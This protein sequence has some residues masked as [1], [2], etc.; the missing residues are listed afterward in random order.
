MKRVYQFSILLSV[1]TAFCSVAV[2][3]APTLM[4]FSEANN[5]SLKAAL[6]NCSIQGTSING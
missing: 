5:T 2:S 6:T 3:Q 4:G 1:F